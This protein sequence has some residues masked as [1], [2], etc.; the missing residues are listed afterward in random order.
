[1]S[2][3]QVNTISATVRPILKQPQMLN[4]QVVP[5]EV[6]TTPKNSKEK[7]R[8]RKL[9]S[10]EAVEISTCVETWCCCFEFCCEEKES[11]CECDCDCSGC[12]CDCSGCDFT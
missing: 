7:S 1:M 6:T 2:N 12:D 9:K 10:L 11:C 3:A 8:R 4:T 5:S